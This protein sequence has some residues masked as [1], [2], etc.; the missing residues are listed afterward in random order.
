VRELKEI[1]EV[2][3]V[4]EGKEAAKT[5]RFAQNGKIGAP[6]TGSPELGYWVTQR[7]RVGI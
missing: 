1:E 7:G 4:E 3:E 5:P 2:K 6:V